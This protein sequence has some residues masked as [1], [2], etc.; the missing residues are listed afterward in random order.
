M[1]K[2]VEKR[3]FI[4][5]KWTNILKN[6]ILQKLMKKKRI[7]AIKFGTYISKPNKIRIV[8]DAASKIN[9]FLYKCPDLLHSLT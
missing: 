7:P 3:N 8:F 1:D 6:N 9:D 4:T 2:Y 5:K